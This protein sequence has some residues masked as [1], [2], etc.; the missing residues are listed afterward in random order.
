MYLRHYMSISP[1][2]LRKVTR[3]GPILV[4]PTIEGAHSKSPFKIIIGLQPMS[5]NAIA[6]TYSRKNA[7]TYKL[8]CEWHDEADIMRA[9]LN[10]AIRKMKKWANTRRHQIKYKEGEQ[11]MIKLLPQQFKTLQKVYKGLVRQYKGPS[12]LFDVWAMSNTNFTFRQD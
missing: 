10:N 8:A 4:Q 11:V 7:I 3:Y 6:S 12:Q 9:Y 5:P 1:V 2:R